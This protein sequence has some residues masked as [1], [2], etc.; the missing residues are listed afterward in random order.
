ME[1]SLEGSS[2]KITIHIC[3]V[4][5]DGVGEGATERDSWYKKRWGIAPNDTHSCRGDWWREMTSNS[6]WGTPNQACTGG[7]NL[8][9]LESS[10]WWLICKL[11]HDT[12]HCDQRTAGRHWR[13][14]S[15]RTGP[16]SLSG[17]QLIMTRVKLISLHV[18]DGC[19]GKHF[20]GFLHKSAW[21]PEVM[22]VCMLAFNYHLVRREGHAR[23]RTPR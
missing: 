12:W 9:I 21:G 19:A 6:H 11:M 13:D 14:V 15:A 17:S 23:E 22:N 10:L 5:R 16:Q 4:E 2:I 8:I 18:L 1:P 3:E 7:R 20:S